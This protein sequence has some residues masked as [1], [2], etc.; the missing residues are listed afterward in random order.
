[1]KVCPKR[2]RRRGTCLAS[3]LQA[4]L[5]VRHGGAIVRIDSTGQTI[6]VT[7][8]LDSRSSSCSC[9][10]ACA[11]V[12]NLGH[13][14]EWEFDTV[15]GTYRVNPL[16][17]DT[18]VGRVRVSENPLYVAYRLA[19][20][21]P[22]VNFGVVGVAAVLLSKKVAVSTAPGGGAL[23]GLSALLSLLSIG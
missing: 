12:L 3:S 14:I 11:G 19:G 17:E 5:T 6:C 8:T 10:F 4:S 23:L 13:V 1:M 18:Y 21:L 16:A 20:V 15:F 7:Q 22:I 9:S 2:W